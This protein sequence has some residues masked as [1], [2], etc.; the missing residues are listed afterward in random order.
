MLPN[1]TVFLASSQVNI[2]PIS[3]VIVMMPMY[4]KTATYVKFQP[5]VSCLYNGSN[6]YP[7]WWIYLLHRHQ[8]CGPMKNHSVNIFFAVIYYNMMNSLDEHLGI[9]SE[10]LPV[11]IDCDPILTIHNRAFEL[12]TRK[13]P[14]C[15]DTTTIDTYK[16]ETGTGI[17]LTCLASASMN[18]HSYHIIWFV[19]NGDGGSNV[20]LDQGL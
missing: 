5:D 9:Q 1:G 18:D 11:I 17:H 20:K 8:S 10:A 16:V 2:K 3:G 7:V 12:G 13:P 14:N 4:E 19:T 15:L 6:K